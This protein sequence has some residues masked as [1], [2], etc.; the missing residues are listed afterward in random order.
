MF[1]FFLYICLSNKRISI[2]F[3]INHSLD[4]DGNVDETVEAVEKNQADEPPQVKPLKILI[5]FIFKFEIFFL[6][7]KD[8]TFIY[9][10]S[11]M[12]NKIN[13]HKFIHNVSSDLLVNYYL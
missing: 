5:N 10:Y 7:I 8:E 13:F 9:H 6:E 2:K 4:T 1:H 11:I 12:S 3:N